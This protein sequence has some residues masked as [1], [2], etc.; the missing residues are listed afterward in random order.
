MK[1]IVLIVMVYVYFYAALVD[2]FKKITYQE[3][4]AQPVLTAEPEAPVV[5]K[6]AMAKTASFVEKSGYPL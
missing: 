1:I 4:Q 3:P 2:S 5:A 6:V